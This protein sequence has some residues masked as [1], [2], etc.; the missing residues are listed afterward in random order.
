MKK[1]ACLLAMFLLGAFPVQLLAQARPKG[2]VAAKKQSGVQYGTASYYSNKFQGRPTASGELYDK[3]KMT[4]AHN[5]L[6]LGTWVK[7][8]NLRNKRSVVVQVTDRLH[9]KNKRVV[10]LSRIA[11]AKLGYVKRGL[12]R[13]KVE[14]LGKDAASAQ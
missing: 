6:P 8:T 14:V 7:V 10:D 3:T 2:S 9:H 11:A 13:V 12:A 1:P 4:C 5:S